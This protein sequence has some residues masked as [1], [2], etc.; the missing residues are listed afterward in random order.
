MAIK[1]HFHHQHGSDG[2]AHGYMLVSLDCSGSAI[3]TPGQAQNPTL[4]AARLF[5]WTPSSLC[6]SFSTLLTSCRCNCRPNVYSA[7]T[8]SV[9][10]LCAV[11]I[12]HSSGSR[13]E[14][15]RTCDSQNIARNEWSRGVD[16][17]ASNL[18][19]NRWTL[20]AGNYNWLRMILTSLAKIIWSSN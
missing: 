14:H 16:D 17:R 5:F 11:G 9:W 10:S 12:H 2:N 8:L 15:S 20:E 19:G 18:L 7:S 3:F 1:H 6:G 13:T 4:A